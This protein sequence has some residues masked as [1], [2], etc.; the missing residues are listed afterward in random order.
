MESHFNDK[1]ETGF[2]GKRYPQ[3]A[4]IEAGTAG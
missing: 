3:M 1:A 4:K 2:S